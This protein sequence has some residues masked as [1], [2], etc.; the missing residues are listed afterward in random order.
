VTSEAQDQHDPSKDDPEVVQLMFDFLYLQSYDQ[1]P[2]AEERS[3]CNL[4]SHAKLYAIGGKYGIPHMKEAAKKRFHEEVEK[5]IASEIFVEAA[6]LGFTTTP[7]S[8]RGLRE[9]IVRAM[10]GNAVK[11]QHNE[12]MNNLI[13]SNKDLALELWKATTALPCGPICSKCSTAL[14]VRTCKWCNE[15]DVKQNCFVSCECDRVKHGGQECVK[16]WGAFS[17][18]SDM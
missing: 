13:C 6:K 11:L 12:E 1:G 8:D 17:Y 15:A 9:L 4:V 3:R 10:I 16:H 7:D 18:D 14:V 5:E 2:S